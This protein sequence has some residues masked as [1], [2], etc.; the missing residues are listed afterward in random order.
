MGMG[1]YGLDKASPG[2]WEEVLAQYRGILAEL[3][4]HR[5]DAAAGDIGHVCL[6]LELLVAKIEFRR[7]LLAAYQA[8]DRAA[9]AR[10]AGAG[11]D[12][13]LAAFTAFG[14]SFRRRWFL[15]YKSYGLEL[16]QIRMGAQ[17]ERFRETSRRVRELLD[18]QVDAIDELDYDG[19]AVFTPVT[20]LASATGCFFV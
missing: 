4:G 15:F 8:R 13:V 11:V 6:L 10:L 3:T 16:F 5:D 19:G 17:L 1:Y 7:D 2:I 12:H 9:L 18:G 20:F 14:D